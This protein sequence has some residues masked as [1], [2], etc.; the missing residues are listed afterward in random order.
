MAGTIS[1]KSGQAYAHKKQGD[2]NKNGTVVVSSDNTN[3]QIN[4]LISDKGGQGDVY[5]VTFK[6]KDYAL[7]WYGKNPEDVIGSKQY[8]VIMGLR[9]IEKPS[10]KFIWPE[11]MVTE[12]NPKPGK[13]FGHLMQLIPENY[14]EM[15]D[16][17]RMDGDEKA[18]RFKSYNAMLV[19]GMNVASAMQKLHMKGLSYKDLNPANF[20]INPETGDA[21]IIDNDN[22]S[23]AGAPCDVK[24]MKGYMAPEIPRSKYQLSPTRET[25]YYSLAVILYRL[26]FVDH[27]ME[28]KLW[29]KIAMCTEEAEEAM[30]AIHPV[31]HFDPEND[32]NRPTDVYAPNAISRWKAL[33]MEIRKL[34]MTAFTEGINHPGKR[35]PEGVWINTLAKCRDKLIRLNPQREQ[36]VNFEDP[37]SVP[38]RCLGIEIG[39]HKVALY[40]QKG[41]YQI[42]FDGNVNQ[43]ARIM[44]GITYNKQ[45][46]SLMIRNM[47]DMIWRGWS[48]VTKQLTDI[49]KGKEYPIAP[50]VMIEFQKEKPC[51]RGKIF[52]AKK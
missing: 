10:E 3:V 15:V 22:V 11:H 35:A 1:N 19:A 27:P 43:Y 42:S 32:K 25:D 41:I 47:T 24:G 40:P 30:Y 49:P 13:R 48:P 46:D 21:L 4:Y 5:H 17:L 20:A 29:E 18:V 14:Y 12:K 23:V 6:G 44:A 45:L 52:D 37:R 26:F 36:F 2:L 28:G 51:I 31:F 7:K 8:N 50:G 33:P 34:F 39:S 9:K 16:Y 38:P